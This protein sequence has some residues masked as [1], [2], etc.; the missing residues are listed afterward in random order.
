M[1]PVSGNS[2]VYE[3]IVS[4]G[5]ATYAWSR[6]S[7]L[8]YAQ[9]QD[10]LS[11]HK[12]DLLLAIS[13]RALFLGTYVGKEP[14]RVSPRILPEGMAW[15]DWTVLPPLAFITRSNA[16]SIC[17][18]SSRRPCTV[19]QATISSHKL[20]CPSRSRCLHVVSNN[21][22]VSPLSRLGW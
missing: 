2:C 3:R 20:S 14:A 12:S 6:K 1:T 22:I 5:M 16:V 4:T 18:A 15:P 9:S 13:P 11:Q 21:K 19:L 17:L 10:F 8:P 7:S